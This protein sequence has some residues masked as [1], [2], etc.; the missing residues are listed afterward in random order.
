MTDE[1]ELRDL[2][3]RI[4]RLNLRDQLHLFEMVLAEY[5]RES[6]AAAEEMRQEI[7]AAEEWHANSVPFPPVWYR[8]AA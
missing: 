3:A 1:Q 8:K 4:A 2:K 5:R 7:A 6:E